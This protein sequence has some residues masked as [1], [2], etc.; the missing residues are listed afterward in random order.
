MTEKMMDGT[1]SGLVEFLTWAGDRGALNQSTAGAHRAAVTQV[2]EV[3]A[4]DLDSIDVRTVDVDD[5]ADRFARKKGHKYAQGSLATYQGRFRKAVEMYLDYLSNPAGWKAPIKS[6]G[7]PKSNG[8]D[9]ADPPKSPGKSESQRSTP[10]A[11]PVSPSSGQLITYPFPLR[12][13]GT[14]YFQLP[15]ELP[16]SEVDRMVGFLTS[17]AIDPQRALPVGKA[18]G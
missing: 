13:G 5:L 1:G 8:K 9:S 14:A 10:V 2:L 7:R 6:R 12:S 15:R 16:R 18:D 17:L 11:A 4:D 3:E